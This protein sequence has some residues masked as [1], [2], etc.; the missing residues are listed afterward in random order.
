MNDRL[1][2]REEKNY[3]T[4]ETDCNINHW[5]VRSPYITLHK[6]QLLDNEC[7]MLRKSNCTLDLNVAKNVKII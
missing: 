4:E 2:R 6:G 1:Q 5:K 7:I 3:S